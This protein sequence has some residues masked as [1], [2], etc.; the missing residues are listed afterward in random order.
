MSPLGIVA[1]GLQALSSWLMSVLAVL[2]LVVSAVVCIAF[3][4]FVCDRSGI[5]QAYTVKLHDGGGPGVPPSRISA[6]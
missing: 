3:V 5:A 1:A 6:R 4:E 2:T